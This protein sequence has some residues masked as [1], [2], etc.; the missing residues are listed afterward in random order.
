[1]G[2]PGGQGRSG[3][4]GVLG[5]QGGFVIPIAQPHFVETLCLCCVLLHQFFIIHSHHCL[6]ALQNSHQTYIGLIHVQN[7]ELLLLEPHPVMT[8]DLGMLLPVHVFVHMLV[9]QGLSLCLAL[10]KR[11]KRILTGVLVTMLGY[12]YVQAESGFVCYAA[13]G[14][15]SKDWKDWHA[16]LQEEVRHFNHRQ[17]SCIV[18]HC[19]FIH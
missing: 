19:L 11:H 15:G 13:L 10:S 17:S 3:V 14:V 6:H 2:K 9:L 1:M 8:Q 5:S 12:G 4:P 18:L 16:K 7:I